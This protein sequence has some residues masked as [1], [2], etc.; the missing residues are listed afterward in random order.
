[1]QRA[2][3][4]LLWGIF[5]RLHNP[6]L[7]LKRM[8]VGVLPLAVRILASGGSAFCQRT[9]ANTELPFVDTISLTNAILVRLGTCGV[10][11]ES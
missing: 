10:Y 4:P 9:K 6:I 11:C 8:A 7:R 2:S 5:S 3:S 1:M